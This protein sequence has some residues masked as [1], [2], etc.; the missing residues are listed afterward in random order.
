MLAAQQPAPQ[1]PTFRAD[2]TL[3][4]TDAIPRDQHGRFVSDLTKDDFVVIEDG[5]PQSIASFTLVHGGRVFNLLE[6]PPE[7]PQTEGIVL[8]PRRRAPDMGSGRVLVIFVDDLHFEAQYTPHVK[9]IVADLVENLLHEGD[10]VAMVSSGPSSIEIDPT[11]DRKLVASAAN[12]IRGSAM[13]PAEIF[14][15]LESPQGPG[16]LRYRAQVAFQTM[17]RM[18]AAMEDV[19]NRRKAVLYISTGY[20][21]DPFVD[22][23]FMRDRVMGGRFS[24]PLRFLI[25]EENPYF[26]L[27]TVTADIDLYV[28]MRELTRSANRT[29]ATIYTVDPRG[30]VGVTDAG[31]YVDQSEFR[32]FFN[33]TI[34]TLRYIAEETGGFAVVN[35]ND[36]VSAFKRIDA[37]TSDYYMI[38]Y[39]PSNPDPTRR[40][41]AIEVTV[42][43]P[44]VTVQSR[45]SYSLKTPGTPPPPP[46][47]KA[48]A[49]R[50]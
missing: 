5:E 50:Q 46:P 26:R 47:L 45:R 35:D 36:F 23:R 33:K 28:L 6:P 12:Q 48:P 11:M 39:Y 10:I 16:D 4:T 20:D 34:S 19:R 29:N 32:T 43:R 8:P 3:V 17:Y 38:G 9:R 41:R 27:N 44:N 15:M 14:Q 22:G 31:Q 30:L 2:I 13:T 7:R 18:L 1:Q 25:D 42:K 37:E 24:D 21:F 49:K 40:S